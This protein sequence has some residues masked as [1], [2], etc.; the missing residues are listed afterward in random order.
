MEASAHARTKML[1]RSRKRMLRTP[2]TPAPVSVLDF[3]TPPL[4]TL[5]QDSWLH[6]L[7]F[8]G[9]MDLVSF[10]ACSRFCRDIVAD[11]LAHPT[12]PFGDLTYNVKTPQEYQQAIHGFPFFK[13]QLLPNLNLNLLFGSSLLASLPPVGNPHTGIRLHLTQSEV[14]LPPPILIQP[15][16]L[17][18]L[19][20]VRV[21]DQVLPLLQRASSLVLD[22]C[23]L[24][25]SSLLSLT[26][27]HFFFAPECVLESPELVRLPAD[28]MHD[29]DISLSVFQLHVSDKAPPVMI[30]ALT[31]EPVI[32][33]VVQHTAFTL[34]KFL[35]QQR[36]W[37]LRFTNVTTIDSTTQKLL[38]AAPNMLRLLDLPSES[39]LPNALYCKDLVLHGRRNYTKV[40]LRNK[41]AYCLESLTVARIKFDASVE[42]LQRLFILRILNSHVG[43]RICSNLFPL[44]IELDICIQSATDAYYWIHMLMSLSRMFILRRLA[45]RFPWA[46]QVNARHNPMLES[47]IVHPMTRV[48]SVYNN[49]MLKQIQ[50]DILPGHPACHNIEE[51]QIHPQIPIEYVHTDYDQNVPRYWSAYL[52]KIDIPFVPC[53]KSVS[54]F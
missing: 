17:L 27:T 6:V 42:V 46:A 36:C 20:N 19:C 7:S 3:K 2:V 33:G 37:N 22:K 18:R 43:F 52:T 54:D 53:N 49:P 26:E 5:T 48:T 31:S 47:L 32:A 4:E 30:Q 50:V 9:L 44:L 38:S 13:D 15:L 39:L 23:I 45:L 25:C 21:T 35:H 14:N 8:L 40:D 34:K 10:R 51:R 41:Y 16:V 29:L 24:A 11:R 1:T 12:R 28:C